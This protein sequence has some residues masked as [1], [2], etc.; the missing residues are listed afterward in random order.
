MQPKNRIFSL[1]F[2][3]RRLAKEKLKKSTKPRTTVKEIAQFGSIFANS[4]HEIGQIISDTI[5]KWA[6]KA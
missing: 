2:L 4:D 1:L 6:K 5:A 3:V